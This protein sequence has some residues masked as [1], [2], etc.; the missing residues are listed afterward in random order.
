MKHVH[1][2]LKRIVCFSSRVGAILVCHMKVDVRL[3]YGAKA[4]GG[5][6][7]CGDGA[8]T[9]GVPAAGEGAA[10]HSE[11]LQGPETLASSGQSWGQTV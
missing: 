4:V 1:D 3:R 9:S 11:H 7:P 8:Q 6:A 2:L 10:T 5:S